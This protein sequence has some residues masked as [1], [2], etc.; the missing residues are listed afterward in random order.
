[1]LKRLFIFA[2]VAWAAF[3]V[4]VASVFHTGEMPI[5]QELHDY[6]FML[7]VPILIVSALFFGIRWV[8]TGR[9]D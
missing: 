5:M 6:F 1:M 4:F 8:V 7:A 3:V 9:P 2:C